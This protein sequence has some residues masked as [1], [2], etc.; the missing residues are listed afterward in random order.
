[1]NGLPPYHFSTLYAPDGATNYLHSLNPIEIILTL[2]I[3]WLLG[4]IPAYNSACW[5][6]I[7]MTAF[8]GYLLSREV[9]GSRL[10]GF[11]AGLALGFAPHQF[12]QLL[13]HMDVAS[14]YFFVLCTWCLY[15]SFG[16]TGRQAV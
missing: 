6:A 12:A 7:F 9:T 3:Q 10:A 4:V 14:I 13:G 2:P 1:S 8:G 16:V 5:M 15:R 11:V